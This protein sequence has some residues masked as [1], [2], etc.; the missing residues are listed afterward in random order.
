MNLEVTDRLFDGCHRS[1]SFTVCVEFSHLLRGVPCCI[2]INYII[3]NC[4]LYFCMRSDN[5]ATSIIFCLADGNTVMV[6]H[7]GTCD[8]THDCGSC[9]YFVT[10][11][12]F[13][14]CFT[15][16]VGLI[17]LSKHDLSIFITENC[18]LP[19]MAQDIYK[20]WCCKL[21]EVKNSILECIRFAWIKI[22]ER[23]RE[24]IRH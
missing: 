11:S 2:E 9:K 12:C 17:F 22:N 19:K 1:T 7:V 24:M 18:F 6:E 20:D 13:F 16:K 21:M 4:S 14:F 8:C 23:G 15:A 5:T 3:Q 10:H